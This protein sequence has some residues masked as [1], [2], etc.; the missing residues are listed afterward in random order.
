MRAEST[1]EDPL[2]LLSRL[3][4]GGGRRGRGSR[5]T[6]YDESER[7]DTDRFEHARLKR[8]PSS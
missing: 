4:E 8:C 5:G 3:D 7:N 1:L 6:T 2:D